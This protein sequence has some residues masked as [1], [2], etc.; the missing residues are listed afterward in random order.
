MTA[1]RRYYVTTPIYYVNDAPTIGHAYTTLACDALARF[2]RLDGYQVRFLTGTDEHGQKVAQA[3]AAAGMDPQALTDKVSQNFRDLRG[4]MNFSY[5]D[6]IRTTEP[7]HLKACQALWQKLVD[8]GDIYLGRFSGWYAV[9]DEAFYDESELVDGKAP[10]GATVEWL[11]E[12]NYFFRLSAWQDRL[13]KFYEANPSFIA[14]R[15]RRNEVVSFVS[16]GLKDLSVSRTSFTWGIPVPGDPRHVMYVW[17][18]AL[19]NYIAALGYPDTANPDFKTFWPADLHMVGKDIIRFHCVYWPAFLMAAGV[20]PPRRVFAHGWWT[21]EGQ[22][23]SKSLGNFVVAS[24]LVDR[25]GRDP[26]RY[27][28]LRELTFGAD[29]DFS[30]AAMVRRI[31]T[32][33]ANDFGNLVQRVLTQVARN[34]DGKVP[35]PGPLSEQ[36]KALLDA[37]RGLLV[38]LRAEYREQAFHRALEAVWEVVGA[39]NRYVDDQAPWAL[40]KTDPARM[41]TVL[42]VLAET[43]RYLAVLSQPVIPES[44]ARILD[45]LAVPE[46]RRSFT[47]LEPTHAL[48]PGTPLPKPEGVFPRYVEEGVPGTEPKPKAKGRGTA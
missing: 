16:G 15:T 4:V 42:W 24:D 48:V 21:N 27:F 35:S 11:E 3:A 26:V 25:Y 43:I 39:A 33:L 9:R 36:D 41:A 31:N 12:E 47:A 30:H 46:G 18:D 17:I 2:M 10:T 1:A 38:R 6:F 40:K 23:M 28:L 14:P 32:D 19:T 45:Q 20:E 44:A 37:A 29:G 5:D 34:C 13:L 7:R 22:K 8:A